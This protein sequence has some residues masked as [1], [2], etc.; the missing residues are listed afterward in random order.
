MRA[1]IWS[2][3]Q[4]SSDHPRIGLSI[5][6]QLCLLPGPRRRSR[7]WV[8]QATQNQQTPIRN[9]ARG[10]QGSESPRSGPAKS[11]FASPPAS[12]VQ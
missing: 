1:L 6:I 11:P 5:G 3:L 10:D 4:D 7:V 12:Q 2:H 9:P 8:R